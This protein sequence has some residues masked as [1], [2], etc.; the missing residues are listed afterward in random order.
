ME[1]RDFWTIMLILGLMSVSQ[2]L[3]GRTLDLE[4]KMIAK[5]QEEVAFLR[6]V[7]QNTDALRSDHE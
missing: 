6:D 3:H 2:W 4:L 1:E 5:L 7:A